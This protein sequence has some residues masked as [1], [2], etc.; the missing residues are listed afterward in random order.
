[1]S[2]YKDFF[3]EKSQK[4]LEPVVASLSEV[5]SPQPLIGVCGGTSISPVLACIRASL[6]SEVERSPFFN[7]KFMM[8]DERI[9]PSEH[10]DSNV[11]LVRDALGLSDSDLPLTLTPFNTENPSLGT[12]EYTSLLKNEGG[13]F[14]LIFLGVGEDAHIA[15]LFPG[16]EWASEGK[17]SFFTFSGSPKPPSHR[18]SAC[19]EV[20]RSA[21]NVVVFFFGKGKVDAYR[22]F[23]DGTAS[24]SECPVLLTKSGQ[25]LFVVRD[26]E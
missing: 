21:R 23:M 25:R 8:I 3:V 16:L 14:D 5:L 22:S 12:E 24:V 18:M 6:L 10:E 2:I 9:V 15:G 26:I 1:M 4:G 11:R 7:A 19:P 13:V 17:E 20:I